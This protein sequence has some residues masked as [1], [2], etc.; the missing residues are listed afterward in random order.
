MDCPFKVGDRVLYKASSFFRE[1]RGE[2]I[3]RRVRT[4]GIIFVVRY[5]HESARDRIDYNNAWWDNEHPST[6]PWSLDP[7]F[8][9]PLEV[10]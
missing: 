1:Y 6:F 10:Y 2:I 7:E 4:S 5:T 3:E 8:G 9:N